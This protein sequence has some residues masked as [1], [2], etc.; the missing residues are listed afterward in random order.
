MNYVTE[1]K[2]RI[3]ELNGLPN[4]KVVFYKNQ[5][6]MPE[7]WIGDKE[8]LP[9]EKSPKQ[10]LLNRSTFEGIIIDDWNRR[11][12]KEDWL[13]VL[14]MIYHSMNG[15]T[16]YVI[17]QEF[18]PKMA[19]GGTTLSKVMKRAFDVNAEL[20]M[21]ENVECLCGLLKSLIEVHKDVEND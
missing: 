10:H 4:D 18:K 20:K 1:V 21:H 5:I 15:A 12:S 14:T 19:N 17:E 7:V 16:E 11:I 2:D 13:N 8:V 3:S 9:L 6:Y